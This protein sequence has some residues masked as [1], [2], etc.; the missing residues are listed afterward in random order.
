MMPEANASRIGQDASTRKPIWIRFQE[1]SSQQ[2]GQDAITTSLWRDPFQA[3]VAPPSITASQEPPEATAQVDVDQTVRPDDLGLQL[4]AVIAGPR[5]RLAILG[6]QVV[7]EG[8]QIVLHHK[9]HAI[10]IR[11]AKIGKDNMSIIIGQEAYELRLPPVTD[12][13]APRADTT[14]TQSRDQFSDRL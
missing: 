3:P 10:T 7:G 12:I 11:I 4:R 5:C 13:D 1:W 6:E 9:G 14:A 8:E 2:Q